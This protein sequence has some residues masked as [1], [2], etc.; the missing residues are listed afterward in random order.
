MKIS[1]DSQGVVFR[2]KADNVEFLLLKRYDPEQDRIDFRLVKGGIEEGEKP[3]E[4]ILR[5]INEETGLKN[6]LL[7]NKFK[8]YSYQVGE[9]LH[10]VEVFLVENT[11]DD[12]IKVDSAH[13]GGFIIESANWFSSQEA[14]KLLYFDQEKDLIKKA[15]DLI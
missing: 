6:L 8:E 5:E 3:E 2:K 14:Q 9:L 12:K 13:E 1:K 10:E 11:K 4:T 7:L 15:L